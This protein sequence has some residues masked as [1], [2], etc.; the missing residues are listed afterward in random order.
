MLQ[1]CAERVPVYVHPSFYK[2]LKLACS[3]DVGGA[4]R[5]GLP[6]SALDRWDRPLAGYPIHLQ[7][8]Y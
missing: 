7:E 8:E 1:F 2:A 4:S 5:D 3:L 6:S